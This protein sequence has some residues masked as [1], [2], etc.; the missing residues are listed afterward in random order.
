MTTNINPNAKPTGRIRELLWDRETLPLFDAE[1]LEQGNLVMTLDS[2]E[3]TTLK[4][5]LCGFEDTPWSIAI[6]STRNP[7]DT[8]GTWSDEDDG[9]TGDFGKL[10]GKSKHLLTVDSFYNGDASLPLAKGHNAIKAGDRIEVAGLYQAVN[11]SDKRYI[12]KTAYDALSDQAT[13]EYIPGNLGKVDV[14]TE[15][16]IDDSSSVKLASTLILRLAKLGKI[17]GYATQDIEA[18]VGGNVP[19]HLTIRSGI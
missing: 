5:R 11:A 17:V 8:T 9:F 12:D 1:K 13:Y 6:R 14:F 15:V 18:G 16:N 19:V 3:D 2:S 4:L 7:Y 10:Q